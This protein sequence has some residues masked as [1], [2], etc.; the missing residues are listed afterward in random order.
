M[1]R[2]PKLLNSL[3]LILGTSRYF[4]LADFLFLWDI[5]VGQMFRPVSLKLPSRW[6]LALIGLILLSSLWSPDIGTGINTGIRILLVALLLPTWKIDKQFHITVSVLLGLLLI[7]G[8]WQYYTGFRPYGLHMNAAVF[9]WLGLAMMPVNP[10]GYLV[11]LFSNAKLAAVGGILWF[12]SVKYWQIAILFFV[13]FL[14]YGFLLFPN[15]F[16]IDHLTSSVDRRIDIVNGLD[17][18]TLDKFYGDGRC[19]EQ[20]YLEFKPFGYGFGGF[21]LSTGQ[22]GPHNA[23]IMSAYELGILAVPFWIFIFMLAKKMPVRVWLPLILVC[24]FTDDFFSRPEGV[25]LIGIWLVTNRQVG[26][27]EPNKSAIRLD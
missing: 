5:T 1:E 15:R 23:F 22:P 20:K 8:V 27:Y 26:S 3:A 2:P 14:V 17:D 4:L 21:C 16:T 9:G 10:L 18:A 24:A 7:V 13:G 25:Y 12:I 19:G 11:I 6:L